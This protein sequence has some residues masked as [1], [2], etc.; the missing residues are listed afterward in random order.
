MDTLLMCGG[1]GTRLSADAEKPLYD[2]LEEP[3]VDCVLGALAGSSVDR[4]YP[5]VSPHVPETREHLTARPGV[6]DV[7]ETP[8]E[9]YVADLG[10]AL[11][12]AR[13]SR[14]ILTVVVDLPLLEPALVDLALDRYDGRDLAV[15]VP[16]ALKQALDLST[17][18][19][20]D[21][22][23]YELSA[24]GLNVVG[25][26]RERNRPDDHPTDDPDAAVTADTDPRPVE[27]VEEGSELLIVSYDARLAVN[28]NTV[29][30][31]S[32]AEV[33]VDGP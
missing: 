22:G 12:D 29:D 21:H 24:T 25:A 1:R 10:T 11:A 19:A 5:V 20:R 16:T 14:P 8:G 9:G 6:D 30:D 26:G 23:G 18:P 28:V 31:A 32:V 27:V 15:V 33:L 13:V 2:I 17:D 3:L 4:V 7:I